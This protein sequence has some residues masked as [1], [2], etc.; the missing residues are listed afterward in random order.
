MGSQR[1][2]TRA[3]EPKRGVPAH[4]AYLRLRRWLSGSIWEGTAGCGANLPGGLTFRA[5][6]RG[7]DHGQAR[8]AGQSF[9][10]VESPALPR[11]YVAETFGRSLHQ[12]GQNRPSRR[13]LSPSFGT[14]IYSDFCIFDARSTFSIQCESQSPALL[15]N[16]GL[17]TRKNGSRQAQYGL[18]SQLCPPALRKGR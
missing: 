13:S 4:G 5:S 7:W 18:D 6:L 12:R 17:R 16:S 8:K 11:P 9:S 10:D 14:L 3:T 15:C 2:S 1:T